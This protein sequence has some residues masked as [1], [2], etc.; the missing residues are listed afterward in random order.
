MAL[1]SP[2]TAYEM[3]DLGDASVNIDIEALLGVFHSD[4][5]YA[6]GGAE[7]RE[8]DWREGYAKLGA[9][10]ARR[11]YQTGGLYGQVSVIGSAT[12]G[13]GDAAGFTSGEERE[14]EL[15]DALLG[16]R[17][18]ALT[19]GDDPW[20]LDVSTGRQ[21][22]ILGDGFLVAGDALNL[23][24]LLGDELDRGGAYY[25]AARRAFDNTALV[26]TGNETWQL[27]LAWLASDNAAQAETELGAMTAQY[28][29]GSGL[30]EG[31]YLRGLAVNA[32]Q[33]DPFLAERD[34]MN[35]YSVRFEQAMIEEA[36]SLRGEYA[37]QHK[38]TNEDAWY[39][40]PSWTFTDVP[41]QPTV[42][43]RY[44]RFSEQWDPLFYGFTR[45]YGT[46][47]QGEVAGNYA[48]PFN[49]NS[50]V[51]HLG[52]SA[53]VADN[54]TL[55]AL[56]FDFESLDTAAQANLDGREF[57]LYAEWFPTEML[58]VS[59]LIGWYTPDASASEGGVQLSDDDTNLYAQIVVGVFF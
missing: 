14:L 55:G 49:S 57:N 36:L 58:Y 34:G 48:G 23:G 33:A 32:D 16:Y 24:N 6:M 12:W 10:Y 59:P 53:Q 4:Y 39:L 15:E 17:H 43:L 50:E 42:S 40:E 54:L 45:G 8:Y 18:D 5:G 37:T 30:M 29:H 22:V 26:R 20:T 2:A 11:D 21:S 44:S 7:Q 47:F 31:T 9:A 35:V 52:V 56:A 25:L 38:D 46:W 13:D 28:T 1:S 27:Q 41:W 3:V 19:A 51:W